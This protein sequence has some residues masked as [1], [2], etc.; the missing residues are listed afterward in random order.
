M[1]FYIPIV[2]YCPK[3]NVTFS[4]ANDS[5]VLRTILRC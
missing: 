5:Q 1:W 4:I 2:G 3:K